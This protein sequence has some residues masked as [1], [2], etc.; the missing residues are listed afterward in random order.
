MNASQD[1]V[2][3]KPK[4]DPSIISFLTIRRAV[5]I[6]GILLPIVSILGVYL[7][8]HSTQI[9]NSISHYYYTIMGN[10]F[11]G[12]LCAVALFLYTYKGYD[13]RDY[14][15]ARIG[16]ICAMLVAFFPT[17]SDPTSTCQFFFTPRASSYSY[18]HF[19]AAAILFC[20]FAYFSLFLFTE[21]NKK[22]DEGRKKI[23]RNRI[24][25]TCGIVILL[26]IVGIAL[27]NFVP[28]LDHQWAFFKP[29]LFFESTA[30]F[31][32]GFSWLVKGETLF[33]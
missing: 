7:F 6:L 13:N 22:G 4:T 2:D 30:L 11:V 17:D 10:Y 19:T 23:M 28:G 8:D 33:A 27:Y 24:Y 14:Y 3:T 32:F 12:T 9:Q 16:A 1:S 15:T 29:V 5:G 21:T 18:I 25:I 20:S 31:A 26:S